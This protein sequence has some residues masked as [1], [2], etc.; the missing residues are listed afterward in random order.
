MNKYRLSVLIATIIILLLIGEIMVLA[1]YSH[2]SWYNRIGFVL[3]IIGVYGI[4]IGFVQK[5]D[6]LKHF[7]WIDDM[8]SP[9]PGTFLAGNLRFLAILSFL[10]SIA[11]RNRSQKSIITLGC[12]G[13]ILVLCMSPFLFLYSLVHLILICPFAYIGYLFSSALLESIA[14]SSGDIELA[15]ITSSGVQ[16]PKISVREILASN[17]AAAKSFLIGIP[18]VLL[19]FVTKGIG[20]FLQ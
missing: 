7:G 11:L 14:G 20:M 18:A 17:P 3:Q 12:F 4:G 9:N 16:S 19:A 15:E 8:T 6:L 10:P 13:Q 5:S 2:E 1:C